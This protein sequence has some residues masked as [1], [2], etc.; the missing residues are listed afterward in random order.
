MLVSGVGVV[1]LLPHSDGLDV[2]CNS[3]LLP[4]SQQYVTYFVQL[5]YNREGAGRG[6]W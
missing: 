3:E 2:D 1:E 6:R 4:D 5:H